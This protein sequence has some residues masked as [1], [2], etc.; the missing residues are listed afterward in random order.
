MCSPARDSSSLAKPSRIAESWLP[1][2]STTAAPASMR[3]V[4][5]VDSSSTVSGEGSA[6]S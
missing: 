6:R 3:R 2:D 1:L 5:A 4:T